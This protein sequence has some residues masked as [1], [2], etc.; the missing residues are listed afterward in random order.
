ME[1]TISTINVQSHA[2]GFYT[3]EF[4]SSS[5]SSLTSTI[6][7]GKKNTKTNKNNKPIIRKTKKTK[8]HDL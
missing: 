8:K 5:P 7:G 2:A 3:A 6:S 1:E 4:V